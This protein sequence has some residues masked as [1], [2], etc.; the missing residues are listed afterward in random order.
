[1]VRHTMYRCLKGLQ[2]ALKNT[3]SLQAALRLGSGYTH[4]PIHQLLACGDERALNKG[5]TMASTQHSSGFSHMNSQHVRLQP[6]TLRGGSCAPA[7]CDERTW[8]TERRYIQCKVVKLTEELLR[9]IVCAL[10]WLATKSSCVKQR[11]SSKEIVM[12]I[13][14]AQRLVI[15]RTSDRIKISR[16]LKLSHQH[17]AAFIAEV[18]SLQVVKRG[19]RTVQ[20]YL[21]T[22]HQQIKLQGSRAGGGAH[23][24]EPLCA[25][26]PQSQS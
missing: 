3:K 4:A 9:I 24:T 20:M 26:P 8:L 23:A 21:L 15:H 22:C 13:V 12:C 6:S 11:H 7:S 16:Y 25:Q 19:G 2:N 10:S 1:M 14:F 5:C 17:A 18:G